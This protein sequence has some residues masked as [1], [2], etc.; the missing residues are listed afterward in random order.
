M[1]R[2]VL[3]LLIPVFA[4][5]P[6]LS[7]IRYIWCVL[8]NENKA[9]QIA[10]GYDRLM[11]VA[12]NGDGREPIS[13]RANRA[14]RE[15]RGWGCVLCSL[16]DKIEENHCEKSSSLEIQT[17]LKSF[18]SAVPNQKEHQMKKK[19]PSK[20]TP[21]QVKANEKSTKKNSPAFSSFSSEPDE[22]PPKFPPNS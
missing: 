5:A 17:N 4:I 8:A 19:A 11:N 10:L 18:L 1:K 2:L 7:L 15:G 6:I 3:I 20:P 14:K 13:A 22:P 16:L 9:W 21:K 12:A